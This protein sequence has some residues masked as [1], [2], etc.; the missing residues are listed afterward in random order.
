[1]RTESLPQKTRTLAE[2]R[3]SGSL[4]W[5]LDPLE[6]LQL[7]D[8]LSL[9]RE[10]G[11]LWLLKIG[12]VALAT[13]LRWEGASISPATSPDQMWLGGGFYRDGTS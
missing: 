10:F 13:V 5:H 4:P 3:L 2:S 7:S 6:G 12:D 11:P 8:I 1:M 9:N